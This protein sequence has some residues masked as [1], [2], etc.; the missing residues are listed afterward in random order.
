VARRELNDEDVRAAKEGDP[1][2]V[3]VVYST[4]AG[5]ILG[6][7]RAHGVA[8]AEA[9]MQDVFLALLPRI[10]T[11]TGGAEG[12]RRLAFTI[13]RARMI[14][15]T[16]ARAR[17]PDEVGYDPALDVR[18]AAS[19]EDE[20]HGSLSLARIQ[21]VLTM[22]PAEQREVLTLRVVADLSIEQVAAIVGRSPGAVKQLQRRALLTLRKTLSDQS[23][24]L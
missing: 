5:P 17:R 8:D 23:S 11:V 24:W 18:T 6:Y 12:V 21:A 10:P 3:G 2:A 1:D 15:A 9:V 4:L 20:A 7:L 13:A 14:D 16:R 22:L 19:A